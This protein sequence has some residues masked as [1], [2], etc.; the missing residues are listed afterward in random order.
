MCT[1]APLHRHIVRV[2]FPVQVVPVILDRGS[3]WMA[4]KCRHHT[5]RYIGDSYVI[6][7]PV[8]TFEDRNP[9]IIF[10][11]RSAC[12]SPDWNHF[13]DCFH[14]RRRHSGVFETVN[15]W[16]PV[17]LS[18][19]EL[20]FVFWIVF[21]IWRTIDGSMDGFK[22]NSIFLGRCCNRTD[23]IGHISTR[24]CLTKRYLNV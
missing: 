2:K 12:T 21:K 14:T 10:L 1:S 23:R 15:P 13:Y 9:K 18:W 11:I 5:T 16:K 24:Y 3:Y 20:L 8:E 4:S 7:L 22:Y 6:Y 19:L 17:V